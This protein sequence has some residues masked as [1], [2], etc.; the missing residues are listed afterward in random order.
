MFFQ[1]LPEQHKNRH[2][3]CALLT[4]FFIHFPLQSLSV[5]SNYQRCAWWP[6][7]LC[8]AGSS[9]CDAFPHYVR[10]EHGAHPVSALAPEPRRTGAGPRASTACS[11]K[12]P[13]ARQLILAKLGLNVKQRSAIKAIFL[14]W[15][16]MV[17]S[18]NSMTDFLFL[19]PG[20]ISFIAH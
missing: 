10:L 6:V 18:Q 17:N 16:C 20:K 4:Y 2:L 1:L 7:C 5:F 9:W 12:R 3:I 15:T 14:S 8:G 13:C 11:S 19:L